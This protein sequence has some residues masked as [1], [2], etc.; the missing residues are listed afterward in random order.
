MPNPSNF[1]KAFVNAPPGSI[2]WDRGEKTSVRGLHVKVTARGEKNFFLYYRAMSGVQR[3]PKIGKFPEITAAEAREIA[4]GMWSQI[5]AGRDPSAERK[6]YRNEMTVNELFDLVMLDHWSKPR[7]KE[8]GWAKEAR[9]NFENHIRKPLGGKKLSDVTPLVLREWH[10]KFEATPYA[11]NRSLA[12]LSKMFTYAEE[13]EIRPLNSNPCY[14]VKK[15]VERRRKRFAS[16]L[17]AKALLEFL[18]REAEKRPRAVAFILLLALTGAR[19]RMIKTGRRDNIVRFEHNG[20]IFGR[21]AKIGKTTYAS[22]EDDVI[23]FPPQALKILDSLPPPKDGTLTGVGMPH[24]LWNKARK[25]VGCYDLWARDWRRTF[26]TL[27]LSSGVSLDTIAEVLNHRSTQTTKIYAK[28]TEQAQI[29]AVEG[30]AEA[31][32]ALI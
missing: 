14:A 29:A 3:R 21:M 28:L 22:G 20:K 2:V 24:D 19:P 30:V 17:E 5:L 9:M 26:A 15:F 1:T 7:F 6:A 23:L 31:F 11:G 18:H 13:N 4:R 12:V 27:A 8:S 10:A 25:V 32:D 16:F